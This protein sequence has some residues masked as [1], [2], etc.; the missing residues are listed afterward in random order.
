MNFDRKKSRRF[1]KLS[2]FKFWQLLSYSCSFEL[3]MKMFHRIGLGSR[4][5]TISD[6]ISTTMTGHC[7]KISVRIPAEVVLIT[8]G[9]TDRRTH[10]VIM[11]HTC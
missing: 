8:D 4:D 5:C 7:F 3:A 2:V 10:T 11:V 9:Q 1:S 6:D